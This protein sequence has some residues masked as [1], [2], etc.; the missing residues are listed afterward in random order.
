MRRI[1]AFAAFALLLLACAESAQAQSCRNRGF[2]TGECLGSF[3]YFVLG[4]TYLQ[5]APT[6]NQ[7]NR[8]DQKQCYLRLPRRPAAFHS[9]Y[10]ASIST[11]IQMLGCDEYFWR[12]AS[13]GDTALAPASGVFRI[14]AAQPDWR[15]V[16]KANNGQYP[17]LTAFTITSAHFERLGFPNYN[18]S[19]GR[20][21]FDAPGMPREQVVAA[22]P[23]SN[24]ADRTAINPRTLWRFADEGGGV[25]LEAV[26]HCN[27]YDY[28]KKV[29]T[30][31]Q[32]EKLL[33]RYFL[34]A[35]PR[36]GTF[37]LTARQKQAEDQAVTQ[38][39]VLYPDGNYITPVSP[40]RFFGPQSQS[41]HFYCNGEIAS[42]ALGHLDGFAR[43]QEHPAGVALD[44]DF[45]HELYAR[46]PGDIPSPLSLT[47]DPYSGFKLQV[48]DSE[49][50]QRFQLDRFNEQF[51]QSGNKYTRL[52]TQQSEILGGDDVAIVPASSAVIDAALKYGEG[53][54]E[55][56]SR[57]GP[58]LGAKFA[59]EGNEIVVTLYQAFGAG[60]VEQFQPMCARWAP[61][62]PVLYPCEAGTAP[63]R[64]LMRYVDGYFYT[65]VNQQ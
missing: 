18:L 26:E 1:F 63:A 34:T 31:P 16:L 13:A 15:D 37:Y 50:R 10:T 36:A 51:D 24:A 35:T 22:Y 58:F 21:A 12:Q 7:P 42:C 17:A 14:R 38:A 52:L 32:S 44:L 49:E 54:S 11:D 64:F 56:F 57:Y 62:D 3:E 48:A 61:G 4:G 6:T 46:A 41:G 55:G 19:L 39:F 43:G 30:S 60:F 59:T 53:R 28:E 2:A 65:P 23:S 8:Y 33:Y 25:M 20:N 9:I 29:C 27:L 45:N 47:I 40:A 5:Y